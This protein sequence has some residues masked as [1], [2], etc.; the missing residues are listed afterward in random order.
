MTQTH[1]YSTVLFD[2]TW[3]EIGNSLDTVESVDSKNEINIRASYDTSGGKLEDGT[4]FQTQAVLNVS[5]EYE[6][7]NGETSLDEFA[8]A[9][10]QVPLLGDKAT[11]KES[12]TSA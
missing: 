6:L 9:L 1:S 7:G 5:Y 2:V 12:I 4:T 3:E 8:E 11:I 10:S